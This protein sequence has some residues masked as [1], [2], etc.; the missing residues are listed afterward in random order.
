[1]GASLSKIS[2][3]EV[4][5]EKLNKF[6]KNPKNFLVFLGNPG[7]GKT[8]FCAA[9]I[10]WA[11][12]KFE[13]IRY[14]P[15]ER[16]YQ[17]LREKISEGQGDYLKELLYMIDDHFVMI[18]DLGISKPNEWR[19]EVLF[20]LVDTRYRLEMPTI[21][22]SNLSKQE[23]ETKYN[24]RIASRLFAAQNI[25]VQIHSGLDLRTQGM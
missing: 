6:I 8:Y 16:L 18:D 4:D 14:W 9:L 2:F 11:M 23:F 12:E 24:T 19:E 22:T 3:N 7:I 21:F 10:P 1:M 17:K 15:E 5:N 13:N 25:I 20:E